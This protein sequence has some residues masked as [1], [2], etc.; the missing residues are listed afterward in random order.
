MSAHAKETGLT[1]KN[2]HGAAEKETR[3]SAGIKPLVFGSL[4]EMPLARPAASGGTT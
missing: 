2:S 1:K 3:V 4:D